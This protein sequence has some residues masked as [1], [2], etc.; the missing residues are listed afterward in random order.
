MVAG[1]TVLHLISGSEGP[2]D[3][4]SAFLVLI[5]LLWLAVRYSIYIAYPIFG[6]VMTVLIAATINKM[7]PFWVPQTGGP[8]FVF[9]EMSVGFGVAILLLGAAASEQRAAEFALRELNTE[10]EK[11]VQERT[12]QLQQSQDQLERAALQDPLTALPN[13]RALESHF[14]ICE[15]AARRKN[16]PFAVLLID[17]DLFKQINDSFG[18]DVGDA[19]LV[20]TAHR[21]RGA[22]RQCDVV[23]R[24]GG[25]E[26][27]ILLPYASDHADVEAVCHRIT[28]LL[29]ESIETG[30]HAFRIAASL[31][32]AM[33]PNDGANWQSLYKAADTALYHAKQSGRANWKWHDSIVASEVA[34]L[35]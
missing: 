1:L 2:G 29:S 6:L 25:D 8:L 3:A 9:A 22:V 33:F 5:P 32:I 28:T 31:G 16:Q 18:H 24:M 17:L 21:L 26:F 11:R 34:S 15:A 30:G 12:T 4:G 7:G 27:M 23:A 13:R 20:E 10:L 19:V 14:A 35:T